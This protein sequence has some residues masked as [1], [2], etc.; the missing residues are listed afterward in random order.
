MYG[1]VVNRIMEGQRYPEITVGMGATL[2]IWSD[3][4]PATVVAVR[5]DAKGNVTEID[6]LG[7]HVSANKAVWPAQDYDITPSDPEG[8]EYKQI[9]GR[10]RR[11]LPGA[12]GWDHNTVPAQTW[13]MDK[14][15]RLR[16]T[17]INDNGRRVMQPKGQSDGLVLGSRDYYRDPSF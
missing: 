7:D 12:S 10:L 15:G 17:Y 9:D 4:S 1:S 2:C 16:K 11:K 13:R 6:I 3:R 8:T 5:K 14:T